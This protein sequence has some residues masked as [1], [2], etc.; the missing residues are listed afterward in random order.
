MARHMVR[1]DAMLDLRVG[2]QHLLRR[3]HTGLVKVSPDA[4]QIGHALGLR[5]G[6]QRVDGDHRDAGGLRLFDGRAHRNRV[7]GG[8]HQQIGLFG[9]RGFHPVDRGLDRESLV[10]GPFQGQAVGFGTILG[11]FLDG[12]PDR[13]G[14]G[15]G[16]GGNAGMIEALR[17]LHRARELL[18]VGHETNNI[19]VPFLQDGLIDFLIAQDPGALFSEAM[20]HAA[21]PLTARHKD[22]IL[23]DF[24]VYTRFSVP[25]FG[26]EGGQSRLP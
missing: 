5:R 24:G 11:T 14:D 3:R 20:R 12:L 10:L 21:L 18:V 17:D 2:F 23:V 25:G 15:M 4:D 7:G 8:D 26:R 9:D 13:L 22:Q 16:G 19:T 6:V 1:H